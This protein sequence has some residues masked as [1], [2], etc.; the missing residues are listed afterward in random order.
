MNVTIRRDHCWV[1]RYVAEPDRVLAEGDPIATELFAKYKNVRMPNLNLGPEDVAVL[2]SHI[3]AQT[4]PSAQ[5]ATS[6]S[7]SAP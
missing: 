7:V 5:P 4:R 1:A 2:L 3:Q 6:V